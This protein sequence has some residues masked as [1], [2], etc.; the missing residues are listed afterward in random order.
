MVWNRISHLV[1]RSGLGVSNLGRRFFDQS[2]LRKGY[3]ILFSLLLPRYFWGL[4]SIVPQA[5][6]SHYA[7]K[8]LQDSF[9]W[10]VRAW[11]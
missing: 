9:P 4:A 7:I 11:P 3:T 1:T 2:L 5:S 6:R 10:Y 8:C